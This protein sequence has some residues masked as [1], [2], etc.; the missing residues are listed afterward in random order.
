MKK[1]RRERVKEGRE[2]ERETTSV[3]CRK[4]KRGR[5]NNRSVLCLRRV[6]QTKEEEER[7]REVFRVCY[8]IRNLGFFLIWG[9][10]IDE[11]TDR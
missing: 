6:L 5:K 1:E 11:F 10:F 8:E 2:R 9:F 7:T 3:Y 4:K